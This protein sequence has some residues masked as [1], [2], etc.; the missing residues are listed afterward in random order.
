MRVSFLWKVVY[1]F[2]WEIYECTH[3]I[4]NTSYLVPLTN[5]FFYNGFFVRQLHNYCYQS[6]AAHK[7]SLY[8]VLNLMII[9][10][11]TFI[12]S[13]IILNHIL[14]LL[15]GFRYNFSVI[16]DSR[17]SKLKCNF[18]LT[19]KPKYNR[20]Y[21]QSIKYS[22]FVVHVTKFNFIYFTDST[23]SGY[24]WYHRTALIQLEKTKP[25]QDLE[26][27]MTDSLAHK[28]NFVFWYVKHCI[29]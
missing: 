4:I 27:I 17:L 26:K 3:E 28:S 18:I 14:C 8:G 24:F 19:L 9:M 22:C 25:K 6:Q 29:N 23:M 7:T 21:L 13:F 10:C 16:F 2:V 20:T 11:T 1:N 12:Y 5:R 15:S